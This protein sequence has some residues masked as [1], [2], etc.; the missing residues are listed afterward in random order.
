MGS[1]MQMM[2]LSFRPVT[3]KGGWMESQQTL[4]QHKK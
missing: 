4:V 2:A 1:E 3:V